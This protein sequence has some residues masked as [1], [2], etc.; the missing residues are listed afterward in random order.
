L[1]EKWD[2]KEF[3]Q[4]QIMTDINFRTMQSGDKN[5]IAE[6][7][8][9][10]YTDDASSSVEISDDKIA[11][12]FQILSEHP[13]YGKIVVIESERIPIGYSLVINFWSNEYGGIIA[14]IDELYITPEYRNRGIGTRFIDSLRQS[15]SNNLVALE[16]Q[17]LP[18]N[19]RALKLYESLGFKRSDRNHYLLNINSTIAI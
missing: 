16:L 3:K 12:T 1:K 18:Y 10:L 6:F 15:R 2:L 7:I 11:L 17:V 8:K 13:D 19:S 4:S 9:S 14:N 5:I